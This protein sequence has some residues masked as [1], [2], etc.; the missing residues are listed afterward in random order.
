MGDEERMRNSG[1]KLRIGASAAMGAVAL[2]IVAV[3]SSS[4]PLVVQA[5]LLQP[6]PMHQPRSRYVPPPDWWLRPQGP[7]PRAPRTASQ[8]A[9]SVPGVVSGVWTALTGPTT[10]TV[11]NV[12]LLTDGRVLAQG[13]SQT[14]WTLTPDNTGSYIDGTWNQ[15]ASIPADCDGSAYYPLYYASAV[16]SDG[17]FV[18]AGGEY[19]VAGTATNQAAIYDPVANN[20]TCIAPPT[21]WKA[22]GDAASVVLPDGTWMVADAYSQE[23]V[24]L[25]AGTNPPTFNLPFL[26]P[27]ASYNNEEGWTLLPTGGVLTLD[28][29]NGL[30]TFETPALIYD[31]TTQT[32]SSTGAA[33]DPLVSG[34]EIGPATLRP[35]G[36]VFAS[37]ANGNTAIYDSNNGTWASGP[38]FPSVTVTYTNGT[39]SVSG[40][41]DPLAT[42]DG[43]AALLPDGNVLIAASAVDP[44]CGGIPPTEF[45]EFDGTDLNPVASPCNDSPG[46]LCPNSQ[47]YTLRLLLLPTGQV[48]AP[49][50]VAGNSS[51]LHTRGDSQ[52]VMGA[53]YYHLPGPSDSRGDELP[54]DRDPI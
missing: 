47:A 14:W 25:D 20:W 8:T 39:C 31:F 11:D 28:I 53:N 38:T 32:W 34:G 33:P 19:N 43:P 36:T 1:R 22:I 13:G 6:F 21:G 26:P 27:N 5:Q 40:V 41:T 3:V 9:A 54:T 16:L 15:V 45:F 50:Y 2:A 12:F 18:I 44:K 24:T 48:L 52:F 29:S 23:V 35:D 17:R 10:S 30:D 46:G 49:S 4:T 7:Q 51:N 37:G 42:D